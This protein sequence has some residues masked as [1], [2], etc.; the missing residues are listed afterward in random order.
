[1]FQQD[2]TFTKNDFA[3]HSGEPCDNIFQEKELLNNGNV[4]RRKKF[5]WTKHQKELIEQDPKR[6]LFTS[7][8]GTGKTIV[9]RAKAVQLGMKRKLF[10]VSKKQADHKNLINSRKTFLEATE[11]HFQ[12]NKLNYSRSQTNGKNLTD[13][14]K[15]FIVLFTKPDAHLFH[16]I[17]QEFEELKDHVAVVCCK[18]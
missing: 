4:E 8:Y 16:S 6:V 5:F 10:Y 7:N 2:Q 13:P 12:R 11:I 14:G 1:M 9:L 15:T 3:K 18:G 17:C